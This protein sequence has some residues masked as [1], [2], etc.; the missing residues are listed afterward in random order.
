VKGTRVKEEGDEKQ[1]F[2]NG[3]LWMMH[4]WDAKEFIDK[5]GTNNLFSS[6]H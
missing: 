1:D 4:R 2:A 5:T 6:I 3:F